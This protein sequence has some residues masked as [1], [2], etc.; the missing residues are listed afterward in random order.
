MAIRVAGLRGRT[1]VLR[2]T[3]RARARFER[4]CLVAVVGAALLLLSLAGSMVV[5]AA[6]IVAIPILAVAAFWRRY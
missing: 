5:V 2:T 6:A 1:P 3:P 4:F